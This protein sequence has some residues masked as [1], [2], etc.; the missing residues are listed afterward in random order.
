MFGIF[1]LFHILLELFVRKTAEV[2]TTAV[3]DKT[4]SGDDVNHLPGIRFHITAFDFPTVCT[5]VLDSHIAVQ[6]NA[7]V[8][9]IQAIAVDGIAA[10][11]SL[12]GLVVT[13]DDIGSG[14]LGVRGIEAI[15]AENH[16]AGNVL[17]FLF[18]FVELRS[19]FGIGHVDLFRLCINCAIKGHTIQF[20]FFVADD[21]DRFF[22]GIERLNITAHKFLHTC[23]RTVNCTHTS[24]LAG[25]Q[26]HHSDILA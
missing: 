10:H 14:G 1:E 7:R 18:G 15:L 16:I 5:T 19:Q 24:H 9:S 4:R 23:Q 11:A 12:E 17:T 22:K 13:G 3:A 25:L 20:A 2:F 21:A 8:C 6:S 26:Y